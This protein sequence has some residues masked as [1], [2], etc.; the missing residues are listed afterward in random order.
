MNVR[1]DDRAGV[2]VSVA[3]PHQKEVTRE[4]MVQM[5]ATTMRP[6]HATQRLV[7][8]PMLAAVA[9]VLQYLEFPVPLL[10]PFLKLDFSTLPALIGGLLYG[11]V[12]GVLVEVLKNTLHMLLKNTD[13]LLIGE[14]ANVVAGASFILAAIYL[15]RRGMGKKG[16]AAG[17]VLGTVLMTAVMAAANAY[18]LLPAYAALY[19][20]S[21]E[22]LLAQFQADSV[23]SFVLY[24]IV[25]FNILKGVVLSLAAYPLYV[26][27][28]GRL[29]LR[30]T[31]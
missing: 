19:Q 5:K 23:W 1:I 21:L 20:V 28:S 9:F 13:G 30:M 7:A 6:S 24:S 27:L 12:A 16:F 26:K 2:D 31:N 14:A 4:E 17:L 3:I 22:Q 10:P 29:N 11:P 25:P 8:I 18:F 15:Q